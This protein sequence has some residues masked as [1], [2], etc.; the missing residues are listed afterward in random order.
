MKLKDILA[1]SGQPGLYKYIAQS[2]NGVIVESLTDGKRS[3]ATSSSRVSA[4]GEISV[5]TE[6]D[7]V[8]LGSIFTAM[9][10]KH[11]GKEAISHKSSPEQLKA[12]FAEVLPDYDRD[13]VHVSDMKKII[14]WYNILVTAGMTDFAVEDPEAQEPEA[15]EAEAPAE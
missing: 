15:A 12:L 13:R 4:L 10:E 1:I 14:S 8:S 5:Y 11:G 3:N 7:E 9:F 6:T 2:K